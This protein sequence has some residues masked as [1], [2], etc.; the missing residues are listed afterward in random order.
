MNSADASSTKG[1]VRARFLF[2]QQAARG[3]PAHT[4][5]LAACLSADV[6]PDARLTVFDLAKVMELQ[7]ANAEL[8]EVDSED[9]PKLPRLL[10]LLGSV[11]SHD[12]SGLVERSGPSTE[13]VSL[14]IPAASLDGEDAASKERYVR[15]MQDKV[16]RKQ[17]MRLRVDRKSLTERLRFEVSQPRVTAFCQAPAGC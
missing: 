6:P 3:I 17:S 11:P 7:A 5:S 2:L 8:S 4:L 15:M 10:T 16:R 13:N 14:S 12:R 9:R 1:G